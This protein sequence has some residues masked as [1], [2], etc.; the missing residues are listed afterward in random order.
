MHTGFVCALQES[1]S[2]VL[3]KFCNQI[4]LP[5]KV[6]LSG[7]SQSLCQIPRLGNL[8]WVLEISQQCE[9]SS[10]IIV[11]QFVGHLLGG[12][13]EGLLVTSSKRAYAT[14]CVTGRSNQSPCPHSR[15]LLTCTSVGDSNTGLAR[16]LWGLWVLVRSRF[17]L[18]SPSVSGGYGVWF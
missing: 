5:S 1:V 14:G 18:S 2:P 12:F 15:P 13:R 4:P 3:C 10:G 17:C 9:N 16:S 8:L 6:K 7:G 11:L